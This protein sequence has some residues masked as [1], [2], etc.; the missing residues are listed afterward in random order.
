VSVN[1]SFRDIY[2]FSYISDSQAGPS[3]FMKDFQG[4]F[5]YLLSALLGGFSLVHESKLVFTNFISRWYSTNYMRKTAFFV[6]MFLITPAVLAASEPGITIE[7]IDPHPVEPGESFTV[8]LI[9]QNDGTSRESFSSLG[10]ETGENIELLGRTSMKDRFDLCGGCQKTGTF[11]LQVS[12]DATSGSYPMEFHLNTG[13]I[14]IV[15]NAVIEVDG[16][17]DLFTT[18]NDLEVEQG[19]R[20]SF[21]LEITNT[22]TGAATQTTLT[23]ENAQMGFSPSK[24]SLG[25]I[26]PG[27]K[28]SR[29]IELRASEDLKS[30]PSSIQIILEFSDDNRELKENSSVSAY[31][32]KNAELTV[33]Q[34]DIGKAYID[35]ETRVMVELENTGPG[36]AESLSTDLSC[37]N[38]EVQ[39]SKAFVGSLDSEES[40]P[41]VY[42]VIPQSSESECTLE[43]SYSDS[44]REK[45]EKKFEIDASREKTDILPILGVLALIF[46]SGAYYWKKRERE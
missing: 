18:V 22:G 26:Q 17:P 7:K 29:E 11:Y 1:C 38:A 24:I 5:K 31:I 25:K 37:K 33:S 2:P 27:E 28:V 13:D 4:G 40:V 6:L 46:V 36:E 45:L 44:S 42:T 9:A 16:K 10:V 43:A 32:L 23:L 3:F 35:R 41:T 34:L 39:G 12:D 19:G 21:N 20:T 8:H 30:G 15:E 14:G